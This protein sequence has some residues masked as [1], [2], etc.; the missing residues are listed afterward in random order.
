ME[1]AQRKP[2]T[3]F[4]RPPP[5]W[6]HA[7]KKKRLLQDDGLRTLVAETKMWAESTVAGCLFGLLSPKQ[8]ATEA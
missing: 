5:K 6:A 2:E 3:C 8:F 1:N 7:S 4:S